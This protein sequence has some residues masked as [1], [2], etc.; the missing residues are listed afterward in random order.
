MSLTSVACSMR[1][2]S[3]MRSQQPSS[4]VD[5]GRP[6]DLREPEV[7]RVGGKQRSSRVNVAAEAGSVLEV[8]V[9]R[10]ERTAESR[11]VV[12]LT[13]RSAAGAALLRW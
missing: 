4:S 5:L 2:P 1:S 3:S 10:R 7:E 8:F 12:R 6:G 11:S 13:L 9:H